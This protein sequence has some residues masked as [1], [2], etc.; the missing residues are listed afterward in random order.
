M[1]SGERAL[2][3]DES[4]LAIGA[5]KYMT[6]RRSWHKHHVGNL[7]LT[8]EAEPRTETASEHASTMRFERHRD[9]SDVT[10]ELVDVLEQRRLA[11]TWAVGDPAHS[12]VTGLVTLSAVPHELALLGDRPWV[13]P[14]AGRKRFAHELARRVAQARAKGIPVATLLPRVASVEEH[15]DLIV[16]HDIRAVVAVDGE[17]GAGREI[18]T[19]TVLHYGVWQ[20]AVTSQLPR[21]AAWSPLGRWK[22]QRSL[23]RAARDASTIHW[24]IDASELAQQG[25]SAM[26]SLIGLLQQVTQLRDRG[27]LR[28]ETLGAAAARLSELPAA[29]PQRSILRPAA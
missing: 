28:I 8:I 4:A 9:L 25:R 22:F 6:G 11:A 26:Q 24:V 16:K 15:V 21:P 19:P 20:F 23:G 5:A 1:T 27:L 18:A 14:T 29:R 7:H 10:R 12:A 3:W 17:P 13:G 2:S